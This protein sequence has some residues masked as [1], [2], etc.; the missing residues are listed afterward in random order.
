MIPFRSLRSI[1]IK[2]T[3]PGPIIYKDFR[4]GIGKNKF[5]FWKFR[6]MKQDL[7]DG[8]IHG[9]DE[10]NQMLTNLQNSKDNVRK[11]PLHKLRVDPR[12]TKFGTFI[13]KT[14]IDELPQ[15]FHVLIGDMSL[16]G[17]RPH[18]SLEVAKY[19][20]R[21]NTLFTVKPGLTGLPQISGRSDLDF[22]EEYKLDMYYIENW[23]IWLDL[24]ILLK[25]PAAVVNLR[26]AD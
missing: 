22:E 11:G 1:G 17:P 4:Y 12:R 23:T 21:H 3:S 16:V 7:C 25:T 5:V 18:M 24:I 19:E 13:R 26:S 6:S 15:L 2:L 14:S 20:N 8:E 9:T 10:G